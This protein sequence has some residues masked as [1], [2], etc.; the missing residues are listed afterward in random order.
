[1][2]GLLLMLTMSATSVAVPLGDSV[3]KGSVVDSKTN[4]RL[5]F[6]RIKEVSTGKFVYS[7]RYGNFA[8]QLKNGDS[9]PST[10][11]A[12][13]LGYATDTIVVSSQDRELTVRLKPTPVRAAEVVVTAEDPVRAIMRRVIQ[14]KAL[15]E[16]RLKSYTYTLYTKFIATTDTTTALRSTGRGD[17][18]VV[19]IL[20]SFSKGYYKYKDNYYNEIIQRRQSVNVPPQ[21]NSVVFGT[22]LNI[23][24]D[25]L[26]IIGEE[27]TTPFAANGLDL[28]EYVARSSLDDDTVSVDVRP[29]S[30]LRRGFTGTL[31]IDQRNNLP[32]EVRLQPTEAVNLPFDADLT[33]R[34]TFQIQDS[35]VVPEALSITSS[36]DANLLWIVSPRLDIQIQ[37]IC[38]DYFINRE[39][40]DYVFDQKRV[41]ILPQANA[42]DSSYWQAN[43]RLPLRPE[44]QRAYQEIDLFLNNPDSLEN[45]LFNR[46]LGPVRK[47]LNRLQQPPF[48][49][50]D[51]MLRYNS[52]HGLYLGLG[53]RYNIAGVFDS[54]LQAGYGFG[55]GQLYYKGS[56]RIPVDRREKL[57]MLLSHGHDLLRRDNSQV[58]RQN[59]I[60]ATTFI[61]GNDYG[62]Y[63]YSTSTIAGLS[64][65]WG[66]LRFLG[67]DQ[68]IRPSSIELRYKRSYDQTANSLDY[69]HLLPRRDT[70]RLNPA[71]ANGRLHSIA[72]ELSLDY[73]PTRRISRRGLNLMFEHADKNLIGGD[74]DFSMLTWNGYLR[75]ATMPLWTLDLSVSGSWSWGATPPQ[76]F[77]S[78]ESGFNGI[79]VGNSFRAMRLKEFYGDRS[80]VLTMSHNFGEVIPGVLRIP[81]IASFGI[82]FI[83]FGG[84]AWT[85]FSEQTK[86]QYTPLLQT[87]D[88]TADRLY[89]E[90][91]LSIN[92]LLIFLRLD[93]IA[94]LSQRDRPEF[95]VTVSNALF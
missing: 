57:N 49:G 16:E 44:E 24:D 5:S 42:F 68:F 18:T 50:F 31:Y 86:L 70:Q 1:M 10:I 72:A 34:Q 46:L 21:A 26:S 58:V 7:D 59:L 64:Y 90:A 94:R 39:V 91:G 9:S 53:A 87:T 85:S 60:S 79:A 67:R 92:R 62:D 33:Y 75:T 88:V 11:V 40:E 55:D 23:Y 61:L 28:Y 20:E 66:Q 22:N 69:F 83:L 43:L 37:T 36:L 73:L 29:K 35:M 76:R 32:I 19:S 63:Y 56:T 82:E 38:Y 12:S 14:R 3:L 2:W 84:A 93:L 45:S 71:I 8:I 47:V 48:T 52:I 74:F 41:E 25:E 89:Y 65:S 4:Q 78:T 51:D 27:I 6:T 77:I 81:N 17:T 15:Q 80:L 95:R 30:T 54:K 13:L